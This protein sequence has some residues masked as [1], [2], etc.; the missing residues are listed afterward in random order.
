MGEFYVSAEQAGTWHFSHNGI[1][2]NGL[3]IDTTEID[4]AGKNT[5]TTD[6]TISLDE[7]WHKFMISFYTDAANPS[8]GPR[9]G[10]ETITFKA[11]GDADFRPFDTTT[12]EMRMRS[13]ASA[14]TSV[15][16][17]KYMSYA[18]SANVY[19][20]AD[21]SKYAALDVVTNSLQVIHQKFSTGVNAPLGG[22]SARFDGYFKV[23][24]ETEGQWTF[25]AKFDDRIALTVDGRRLFAG[26]TGTASMTLLE[27]WHRFDIRTGDTTPS[28]NTTYGTGGGL[29]DADGNVVA[30]EFRVNG[31]AYHAFDER[32]VPIAYTAGI[33]QKF[34]KPGL[35]GVTELAAGSTLVNAPRE[36]G[37]CPV[38][39]TLKG[40]GTLSGP[41]RFTGEDNCWE[42]AGNSGLA[43]LNGAV[44][45]D[46]ADANALA[47]L[48]SVKATFN[49]KPGRPEY[50]ISDALGITSETVAGIGLSV[51][52]ED[53]NDYSEDFAL[54][55]KSGKL[56][57][58]NSNP[59]G[60]II[61]FR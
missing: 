33:A 40:A 1:S 45:F 30:L 25:N 23:T 2:H 5:T 37:W 41:F 11:P 12:V 36:G 13:E 4:R 18:D 59:G 55:V 29:T 53:G 58:V 27:G 7:G 49:R 42:M 14:R 24:K 28:G 31:G 9:N 61:L 52:D 46:N 26:N 6:K 56:K 47:G 32:Y 16:W 35:G 10:S 43:K 38:Y 3:Q 48:K 60:M 34:E 57:L 44:T 54:T 39:G 20:D 51:T 50:E 8:F 21:E 19:A 15:R 22:A 17:R